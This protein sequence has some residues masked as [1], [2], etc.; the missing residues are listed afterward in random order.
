M[1]GIKLQYFPMRHEGK[2]F[3][4]YKTLNLGDNLSLY[5]RIVDKFNFGKD[6]LPF[7]L[8]D[9]VNK[10]AQFHPGVNVKN[11]GFDLAK[12][13][14][15]QQ[16]IPQENVYLNWG[17]FDN[18]DSMSSKDLSGNFKDI[19]FSGEDLTLFDDSLNWMVLIDH[20]GSIGT[21]KID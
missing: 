4:T 11:N 9:R 3:P 1:Q 2:Q 10:Q 21:L 12:F 15:E 20:H 5:R 13:L 16:I 17:A 6:I 14:E 8:V 7:D 19:W 18:I